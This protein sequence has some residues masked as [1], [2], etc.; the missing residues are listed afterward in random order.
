M[1]DATSYK[2]AS[3]TQHI[4]D[5]VVD[6]GGV[7]VG[8]PGFAVI[9]GPC[10]VES[11]EQMRD[12]ARAVSEAGAHILRGGAFKPRTSPYSF[13]GLG[14]EGLAIL[15]EVGRELSMPAFTE[16]MEVCDLDLVEESGAFFQV[17][18]RNMRNSRLLRAVG[19]RKTPVLLKRGMAAT[20]EELLLAAE[21]VLSEGNPNVILCERGIATFATSTRNTL[22]LNAVPVLKAKTHLPVIVDP[23]HGTGAREYVEPMALAA[24]AAGADG[25]MVEVHPAPDKARSDGRQSLAPQQFGA[26]M[27]A[28]RSLLGALG[29][30]LA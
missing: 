12:T 2:L 24:A 1:S 16:V 26:L 14:R 6:V 21:Y 18:S 15:Q 20:V 19:R 13:Q 22:D 25:L 30:E 28:L 17:G 29:R 7:S 8:G 9:A 3:R 23:S 11:L 27:D 10:A 4:T 5:T